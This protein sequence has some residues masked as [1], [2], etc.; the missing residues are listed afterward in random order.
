MKTGVIRGDYQLVLFTPEMQLQ[1]KQWRSML[2]GKVYSQRLRAFVV[3]EA[4]IVKQW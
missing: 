1:S 3:D 2:L 4:H